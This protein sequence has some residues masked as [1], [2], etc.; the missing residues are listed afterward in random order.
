LGIE[1]CGIS[2]GDLIP[3]PFGQ[4]KTLT[5]NEGFMKGLNGWG[6]QLL[7]MKTNL[8]SEMK[9]KLIIKIALGFRLFSLILGCRAEISKVEINPSG[10]TIIQRI[11]TPKGTNG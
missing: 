2:E 7:W 1:E 6:V 5:L 8:K 11:P 4:I 10:N 9:N 3:L